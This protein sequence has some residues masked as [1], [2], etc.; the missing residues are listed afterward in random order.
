MIVDLAAELVSALRSPSGRDALREALAPVVADEIKRALEEQGATPKPLAE[1]W[2]V[3]PETARGR[4]RRDP[5]LQKLAIKSGRRRLY[6]P[7][8]VLA[9]MQGA[10]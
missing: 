9:Y 7:H 4:E 8:Q 1:I 6:L 5:G 2:G 3:S 10:K